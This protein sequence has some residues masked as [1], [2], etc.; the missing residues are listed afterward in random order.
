MMDE[1]KHFVVVGAFTMAL[2]RAGKGHAGPIDVSDMC[3][4]VDTIWL[5]MIKKTI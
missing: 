2:H 3:T 4:F 5:H 1:M